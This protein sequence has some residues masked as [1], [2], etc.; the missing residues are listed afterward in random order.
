MHFDST[1]VIADASKPP[2][3]T[4]AF[5][6]SGHP[7][8]CRRFRCEH[9]WAVPFCRF[10][11]LL[12]CLVK[13]VK[14]ESHF[15]DC[16]HH[17][18]TTMIIS[19]VPSNYM[20]LLFTAKNCINQCRNA[21]GFLKAWAPH[22]I[23]PRRVR[24]HPSG[25]PDT[26]QPSLLQRHARLDLFEKKTS[27][28][29]TCHIYSRILNHPKSRVFMSVTCLHPT[30][31]AVSTGISRLLPQNLIIDRRGWEAANIRRNMTAWQPILVGGWATP[32]KNM[33]VNWDDYSPYM[34]K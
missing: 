15:M 23:E 14:G 16:D 11:Y 19:R 10:E 28:E 4:F 25:S 26:P 30:S 13:D 27:K 17:P 21:W 8:S 9:P 3:G 5:Q 34:G 7:P 31:E 6:V 24:P 32:L 20:Q 33:K 12:Q 1:Q 2:A 29:N 22:P 18:K